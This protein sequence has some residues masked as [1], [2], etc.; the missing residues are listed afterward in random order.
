MRPKIRHNATSASPLRV[1]A[2]FANNL[3]PRERVDRI[4]SQRPFC[5]CYCWTSVESSS[6]QLTLRAG[7]LSR[8]T[9][10]M[11]D[12]SEETRFV[13]P[14]RVLLD[15]WIRKQTFY[16]FYFVFDLQDVKIMKCK[17]YLARFVSLL[18]RQH[19]YSIVL[20]YFDGVE[21]CGKMTEE[22]V[23]KYFDR[24][25]LRTILLSLHIIEP[26][27]RMQIANQ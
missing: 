3:R 26:Q 6:R 13:C 2:T 20:I 18:P 10:T 5:C 4:R 27:T 17:F 8:K 25:C 1:R 21:C 23:V 9:D 14:C 7:H 16:F 19:L 12:R 24:I 22:H 11:P 15:A